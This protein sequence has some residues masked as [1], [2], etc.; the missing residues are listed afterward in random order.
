MQSRK[1]DP[2]NFFLWRFHITSI[3]LRLGLNIQYFTFFSQLS[4]VASIYDKFWA[5]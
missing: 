3:F 2:R 5:K 4:F 1:G